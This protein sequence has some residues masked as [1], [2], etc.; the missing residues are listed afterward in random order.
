MSRKEVEDDLKHDAAFT[1]S[2]LQGGITIAIGF[3]IAIF[4]MPDDGTGFVQSVKT[5]S[6][7]IFI[8]V[9]VIATFLY[10]SRMRKISERLEKEEKVEADANDSHDSLTDTIDKINDKFD[11]F[12]K[13]EKKLND[14]H[15]SNLKKLEKLH[16]KVEHINK[17]IKKSIK[18]R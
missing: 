16:L 2:L 11:D 8:I 7:W 12:T 4:L 18:K 9:L 10:I 5:Y 3:L 1:S 13:D 14:E 17:S 6:S 15:A